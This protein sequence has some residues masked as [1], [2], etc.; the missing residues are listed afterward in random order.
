[1]NLERLRSRARHFVPRFEPIHPFCSRPSR[2]NKA[3]KCGFCEPGGIVR[4]AHELVTSF[5]GSNPSIPSVLVPPEKIKPRNAASVNLE[6]L[7]PPTFWSVARCSIQLSYRSYSTF[8]SGYKESY[9]QIN[10]QIELL[11]AEANIIIFA[12]IQFEYYALLKNYSFN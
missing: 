10:N 8:V 5:L 7:E 9:K 1:M 12:I 3:A 2:K 6:G 11:I 4:S